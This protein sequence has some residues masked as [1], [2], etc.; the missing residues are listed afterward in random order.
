MMAMVEGGLASICIYWRCLRSIGKVLFIVIIEHGGKCWPI[1][2]WSAMIVNDWQCLVDHD[3]TGWEC[4][5]LTRRVMACTVLDGNGWSWATTVHIWQW[6]RTAMVES[7]NGWWWS[8]NCMTAMA[9]NGWRC[10]WVITVYGKGW[11]FGTDWEWSWLRL[12][13]VEN[14]WWWQWHWQ[15]PWQATAWRQ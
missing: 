9:G 4:Q 13:L 2:Q 15:W 3:G 6:L 14:G 12:A 5:C 11:E 8:G 1:Q 7:R 10:W